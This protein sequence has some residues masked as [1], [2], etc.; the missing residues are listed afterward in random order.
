MNIQELQ[1]HFVLLGDSIYLGEALIK[2]FLIKTPLKMKKIEELVIAIE[3]S[4][5]SE[6]NK[7]T[8]IVELSKQDIDLEYFIKLLITLFSLS[9]EILDLFN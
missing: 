4:D 5:L 3:E 6:E 7:K 9:K 2:T 1:K 8:L